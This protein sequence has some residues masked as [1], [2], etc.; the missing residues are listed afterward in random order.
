MVPRHVSHMRHLLLFVSVVLLF[1]LGICTFVY[2]QRTSLSKAQQVE[3]R[4]TYDRWIEAGRPE[5][6]S[7][8]DFM[9]GRNRD[10]VVC[11]KLFAVDTT[12]YV[13]QFALTNLALGKNGMLVITT[14]KV[15]LWVNTSG[16][17]SVISFSSSP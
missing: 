6:S 3:L 1:V 4:A 13:G 2:L 12:N 9:K 16:V 10:L 11:S 7:L 8:A 5:G 17:V 15:L 14:N